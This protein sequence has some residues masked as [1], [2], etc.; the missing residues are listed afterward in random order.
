MKKYSKPE[1]SKMILVTRDEIKAS[2]ETDYDN[3]KSYDEFQ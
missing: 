2:T 1:I 3:E